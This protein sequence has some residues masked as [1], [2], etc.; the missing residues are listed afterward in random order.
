MTFFHCIYHHPTCLV[1]CLCTPDVTL[2]EQRLRRNAISLTSMLTCWMNDSI[3]LHFYCYNPI[4]HPPRQPPDFPTTTHRQP[5][6][7]LVVSSNTNLV[8]PFPFSKLLKE[9]LSVLRTKPQLLKQGRHDPAPPLPRLSAPATSVCCSQPQ[10]SH[11]QL[12]APLP[13]HPSDHG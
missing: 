11:M 8:K 4:P 2:G 1:Y 13:S 9:L 7:P 12:S 10:D 3:S 5:I 6:H